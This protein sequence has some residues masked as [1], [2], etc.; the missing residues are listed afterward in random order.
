MNLLGNNSSSIIL[1]NEKYENFLITPFL[2]NPAPVALS[3]WSTII[4][5]KIYFDPVL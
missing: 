3:L 1:R 2:T 5:F 4:M